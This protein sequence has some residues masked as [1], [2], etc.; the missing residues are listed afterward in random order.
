MKD[1]NKSEY[2]LI[3]DNEISPQINSTA[4]TDISSK[5][6]QAIEIEEDRVI[7][8]LSW[9]T[10]GAVFF[11]YAIGF[12]AWLSG[13]HH[14]AISLA[15]FGVIFIVNL[16]HHKKTHEHHRFKLF[17]LCIA[18]ILLL[19]LIASG[20]ESNTGPLWFYIFPSIVFYIVGLRNG[21]ILTFLSII[22]ILIIF[23]FP[24]LP[25]VTTTYNFD[26]KLR[27]IGSFLFVAVF[28]YI[29]DFSRRE[30]RDDLV[31]MARLYKHA[32][33]T[34]ELTQL[35]NRRAMRENLEKE[36]YRYQR[37]GS[38]FSLILMD[39]DHFK[40]VNDSYGHDAGDIVLK[41]FAKQIS[42][43]SRKVDTVARWGGEEFLILLPDTSLVQALALAE[44]IR[45]KIQE[46][47]FIYR[48]ER[49]S[50][51]TSAGVCSISQSKD[52]E[53]MLKQADI[54]LYDAK[55]K[56]RNRIIPAVKTYQ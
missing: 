17:F 52:L 33:G 26:F 41:E 53:T 47:A 9:L 22:F 7:K 48:Y 46:N 31:N 38:H 56:G 6:K 25:F 36:F 1:E 3:N 16:L 24:Q 20:G 49:I 2:E 28:A 15:I 19:Y 50:I 30:A 54:N 27:F 55:Q 32:A 44:R 11:L 4:N 10:Y 37:H 14:Y 45:I 21:I 29:I 5:I 43:L 8:V 39:I 40:K 35:A 18:A 34:D 13:H 42:G 12:K 51:T 23:L